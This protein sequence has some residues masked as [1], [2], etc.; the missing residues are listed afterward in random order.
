MCSGRC[1][2]ILWRKEPD[3]LHYSVGWD[4]KGSGLTYIVTVTVKED[5]TIE[6]AEGTESDEAPTEGGSEEGSGEE[7]IKMKKHDN[8][9]KNIQ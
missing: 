4:G 6:N 9:G 7:T 1:S 5:G 8:Y 3:N 2:G